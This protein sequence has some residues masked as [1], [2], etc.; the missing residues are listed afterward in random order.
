MRVVTQ[1][2]KVIRADF[3]LLSLCK[4]AKQICHCMWAASVE[5]SLRALQSHSWNTTGDTAFMH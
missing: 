2:S 1:V 3:I 4:R 5:H